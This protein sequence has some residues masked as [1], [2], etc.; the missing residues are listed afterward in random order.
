VQLC[1]TTAGYVLHVDNEASVPYAAI[2]ERLKMRVLRALVRHRIVTA[3][4]SATCKLNIMEIDRSYQVEVWPDGLTSETRF[5]I[6]LK[7][8]F[9]APAGKYGECSSGT[10][11]DTCFHSR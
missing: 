4:Q 11:T 7:K 9:L 10:G 8:P 2:D 5:G 6:R 1:C 3:A